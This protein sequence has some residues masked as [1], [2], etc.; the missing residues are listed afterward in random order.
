VLENLVGN[1][2]KYHD[3]LHPLR[4]AVS[5]RSSEDRLHFDIADNGP[6]I[7]PKFHTR[8]FDVFQT[9]R[10]AN[11]PESTGIGLAIVKK[12]VELHGGRI[13]VTSE[14]GAGATF[15]FDWPRGAT[16]ATSGAALNEAA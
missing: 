11:A 7:D 1:A 8:I 14:P 13:A 6:G 10:R 15:S 16:A 2:I 3:G 5:V 12:L 9:L 4:I